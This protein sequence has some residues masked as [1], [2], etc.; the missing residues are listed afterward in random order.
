MIIAVS[1]PGC[2][3]LVDAEYDYQ[4]NIIF[5]DAYALTEAGTSTVTISQSNWDGVNYSVRFVPNA[6]VQFENIDTELT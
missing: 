4:D 5:I 2:I 6:K 3:D 1:I